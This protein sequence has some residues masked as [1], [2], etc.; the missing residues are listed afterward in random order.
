VSQLGRV[1]SL[2]DDWARRGRDEGMERGHRPRALQALAAL[3]IQ[4]GHDALDLGCGNGWAA[5]WLRERSGASGRVSGVDISATMLARA[6]AL[7]EGQNIE[8]QRAAFDALPFGDATF[9][10][11]FSM[12]ALYYAADLDAALGE[13]LRVLRPGGSLAIC[14]DFY[15]ENEDSHSWPRDVGVEMT[16]LPERAWVDRLSAAGF[17]SGRSF[18]CLDPRPAPD[19]LPAERRE[20]IRRF[21]E[22]IGSLA[23]VARRP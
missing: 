23:L 17:V 14:I 22:E 18:R 15:L 2:F 6:E 13:L 11:V 20:A 21:R 1:E 9:D 12:E 7:S 19:E 3:P 8:F 4:E 10:H 5:R 16:L